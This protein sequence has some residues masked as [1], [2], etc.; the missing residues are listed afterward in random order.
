M[1]WRCQWLI[2]DATWDCQNHVLEGLNSSESLRYYEQNPHPYFP[3]DLQAIRDYNGLCC[4]DINWQFDSE[5][6]ESIARTLSLSQ[7]RSS[8]LLLYQ[9]RPYLHL[10]LKLIELTVYYDCSIFT[11][12]LLFN[13][14]NNSILYFQESVN[15]VWDAIGSIATSTVEV[16]IQVLCR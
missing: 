15:L 12:C 9:Y 14:M 10:V 7:Y 8:F 5:C 11:S 4:I 1:G 3:T 16:C 6:H 13:P 2:T